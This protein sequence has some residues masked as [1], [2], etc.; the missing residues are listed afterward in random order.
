MSRNSLDAHCGNS[1]HENKKNPCRVCRGLDKGSRNEHKG[2]PVGLLIAWLFADRSTQKLHG[3]VLVAK[4]R[5]KDDIESMSHESRVRAR[6]WARTN[7]LEH[8][9]ALERPRRTDSDGN[10]VEP[11]EPLGFA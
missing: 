8:L 9:F 4:R 11:E 1:L 5:T 10:F 3:D 2:R 6:Q 7:G